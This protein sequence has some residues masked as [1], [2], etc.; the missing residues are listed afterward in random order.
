MLGRVVQQKLHAQT[1]RRTDAGP[2]VVKRII[3]RNIF[4]SIRPRLHGADKVLFLA[5]ILVPIRVNLPKLELKRGQF[6]AHANAALVKL[7]CNRC[8]RTFPY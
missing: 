2:V 5:P 6:V 3:L 1:R 8:N 4:V 7:S